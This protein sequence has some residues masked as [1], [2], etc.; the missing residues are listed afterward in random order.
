MNTP[1]DNIATPSTGLPPA[2]SISTVIVDGI[3]IRSLEA[4]AGTP[5]VCLHGA[6]GLRLSA[7]H[8]ALAG[9]YRLIA[10][11]LPAIGDSLAKASERAIAATMAKALKVL[12]IDSCALMGH[13]VG[14]N[15]ALWMAIDQPTIATTLVLVSPTAIRPQASGISGSLPRNIPESNPAHVWFSDPV[16]LEKPATSTDP[17]DFLNGPPR[18]PEIEK[19]M[20]S[21]SIPVLA[22]FGTR[23]TLVSTDAARYYNLLMQKCFTTM[24]YD[25]GQD[26]DF[27]RPDAVTSV[28]KNFLQHGESFIVNRDNAI[29]N[30]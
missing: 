16:T 5:L 30:P 15:I 2:I 22:L 28:V 13:G 3:K 29:I 9:H 18:D 14:A 17:D 8:R 1:S 19:A 20:G 26:I 7:T 11:E 24:V 23:S 21:V 6:E 10:L 4:G 27:D 12:D 25:A